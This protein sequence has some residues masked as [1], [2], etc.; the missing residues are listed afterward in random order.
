MFGIAV[1]A[2]T[3]VAAGH[4]PGVRRAAVTVLTDH[5]GSAVTLTTAAVAVAVG[6]GLTAGFTAAQLITDTLWNQKAK[7]WRVW[8][9]VLAGFSLT[10]VCFFFWLLDI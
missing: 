6:G 5:V 10:G 4:V 7:S 2:L 8:H 9:K 3:A 1:A